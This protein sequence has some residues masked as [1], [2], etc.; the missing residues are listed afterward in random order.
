MD[1]TIF[2]AFSD[3]NIPEEFDTL[4][5]ASAYLNLTEEEVGDENAYIYECVNRF[6]P[7]Q[8]IIWVKD[9]ES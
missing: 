4:E 3:V 6:I 2:L 9:D 7:K 1:K 8:K 5:E